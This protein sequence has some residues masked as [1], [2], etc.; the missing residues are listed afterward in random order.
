[1][2]D[3]DRPTPRSPTTGTWEAY[4]AQS[5]A[6][7]VRLR[8]AASAKKA[9]GASSNPRLYDPEGA[10]RMLERA[11]LLDWLT[12]QFGLWPMDPEK[13]SVER[14]TL[15]PLFVGLFRKSEEE[16]LRMPRRADGGA[17]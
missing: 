14:V 7:A 4:R 1:M 12:E 15:G 2:S 11:E 9:P 13:W 10:G 8:F 3:S 16:L 5:K 6:L 17:W